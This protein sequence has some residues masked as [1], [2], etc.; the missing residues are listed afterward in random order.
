MVSL[1]FLFDGAQAQSQGKQSSQPGP[2]NADSASTASDQAADLS[3]ELAMLQA[4]K[5]ACALAIVQ[6]VA[7]A[8][9]AIND[10]R[11]MVCVCVYGGVVYL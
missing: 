1:F 9:I 2:S 11:G 3:R 6:D 7:D 10:V 5:S 8:L 4:A